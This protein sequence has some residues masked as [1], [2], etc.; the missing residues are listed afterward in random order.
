M[1]VYVGEV[2]KS[3][4]QMMQWVFV[5]DGFPL[6][7]SAKCKG[8]SNHVLAIKFCISSADSHLLSPANSSL[9]GSL[10][11]AMVLNSRR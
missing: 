1:V 5:I 4:S 10:V 6:G 8:D 3:V 11:S 2:Y 9:T 7:Y